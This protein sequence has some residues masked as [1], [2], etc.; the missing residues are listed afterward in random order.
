VALSLVDPHYMVSPGVIFFFFLPLAAALLFG[1]VFCGGVCPFGA[2]QDL[3]LLWPK[4]VPAKLDRVLGVL[5]YVYLGLALMFAVWGFFLRIGAWEIALNRRFLICEWDPFVGIF[6]ISGSFHLLLIGAA[7]LLAGMFF[8]RPY[9][10]WLCP[11]GKI[12]SIL[13]R[14]AWK[15]V[16]LQPN[17]ERGCSLFTDACPYGAIEDSRADRGSCLACARCFEYCRGE[18]EYGGA[19]QPMKV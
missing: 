10:R 3:V 9:C 13:S 12:L 7:F 15:N 19:E 14:F 5:P 16:E 4:K 11:Y 8:G 2:L 1:R 6:R 18:A 17:K